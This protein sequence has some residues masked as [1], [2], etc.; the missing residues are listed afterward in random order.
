MTFTA[1]DSARM[2]QAL[3]LAKLAIGV[4]EPNPRVGCVIARD[5][6]QLLGEGATQAVGGPHAEVMALRQAASHG[7]D[8]RGATAWVTLEPCAHHGRTPPCCDALVAA[9]LKRVVVACEDPFPA[10]AG[11]GLQRLRAAGLQVDTAD[12]ATAAAAREINIGFFSRFLRQRPWVRLKVAASLDGRTALPD[13]RSQWITGPQARADGHAWRKRAGAV[14]T[15]LGT[16]LADNPRLD[17]RLVGTQVQPLRVVLDSQLR[18]PPTAAILAPPGQTV[19]AHTVVDSTNASALLAAGAQLLTLPAAAGKVDLQALMQ[20]LT[21]REINELH[22]EA[23]PRLNA[24]L[25]AG[26][27]VDELLVYQAPMLMG[28]GRNIADLGPLV[29]LANALRFEYRDVLRI[30]PDLR[31]LA[32]ASRRDAF[33]D[34]FSGT[35]ARFD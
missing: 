25:L 32:R 13:G 30:G 35:A 20:T 29:D 10:V 9:G 28:A 18:C 7:F 23:G 3:G 12:L 5:D 4:S 1:L 17:V 15:G 16:V 11:Q 19:L 14:L 33:D 27:W 8:V 31:L 26:G 34:L 2:A 24:A 21:Q 22:V 6:G